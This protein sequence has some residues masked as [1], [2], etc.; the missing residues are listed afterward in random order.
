MVVSYRTLHRYA[1]T[2][3]GFGR[4]QATVPVAD[5]KPAAELQI[6]LGRL[7][8]LTDTEDGRRRVVRGLVFTV[9]VVTA[10]SEWFARLI[11]SFSTVYQAQT[12][13]MSN[14]DSVRKYVEKFAVDGLR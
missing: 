14:P 4:R 5:C 10:A 12:F 13:D 11:Y 3:L 9:G 7:G 8:L 6:D 1:T 2:E